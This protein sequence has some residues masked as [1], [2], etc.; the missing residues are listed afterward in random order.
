M[1]GWCCW[2][3]HIVNTDEVVGSSPALSTYFFSGSCLRARP[4][5]GYLNLVLPFL[6][7]RYSLFNFIY[8]DIRRKSAKCLLSQN[9]VIL[10]LSP[11]FRAPLRVEDTPHTPEKFKAQPVGIEP[12][13]LA[14]EHLRS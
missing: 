4:K 3:S 2:L 13:D 5:V 11:F 10:I 12:R 7:F 6:L 1:L 8:N 9:I 14:R